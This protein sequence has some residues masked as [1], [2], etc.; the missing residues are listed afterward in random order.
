MNL[1]QTYCQ[2]RNELFKLGEKKCHILKKVHFQKKG[3]KAN[4][5][6]HFYIS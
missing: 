1:I 2:R 3:S 5:Q 4:K 6:K